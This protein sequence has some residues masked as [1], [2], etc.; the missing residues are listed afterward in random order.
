MLGCWYQCV[1]TLTFLQHANPLAHADAL[2]LWSTAGVR[3]CSLPRTSSQCRPRAQSLNRPLHSAYLLPKADAMQ[4]WQSAVPSCSAAW[5][6]SLLMHPSPLT[7]SGCCAFLT[8]HRPFTCLGVQCP[9]L[10]TLLRSLLQ[11]PCASGRPPMCGS[12]APWCVASPPCCAC[13]TPSRASRR[14]PGGA[15]PRAPKFPS[16]RPSTARCAGNRLQ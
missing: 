1:V 9:Y 14:W 5:M 2:Q 12:T 11:M 6:V 13:P 10:C 4:P 16:G 15:C 7:I 3:I 8:H